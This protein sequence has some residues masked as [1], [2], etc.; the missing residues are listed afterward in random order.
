MEAFSI[1]M[2]DA[3]ATTASNLIE[4]NESFQPQQ[5]ETLKQCG[6]NLDVTE[7]RKSRR[8]S[9][10]RRIIVEEVEDHCDL[11]GE[12][13]S[14]SSAYHLHVKRCQ[15]LSTA[16]FKE[17]QTKSS[18]DL[19]LSSANAKKCGGKVTC[20]HCYEKFWQ[21]EM[22]DHIQDVHG[23]SDMYTCCHCQATFD[24]RRSYASHMRYEH[25]DKKAFKCSFCSN[26]Y[27]LYESLKRHNRIHNKELALTCDECG[28]SF[29]EKITLKRHK[30][31]HTGNI[32]ILK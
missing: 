13:F 10:P 18:E 32:N 3:A 24:S 5:E 21:S 25:D 11:C 26:A 8:K 31:I 16:S 27:E 23:I 28:K 15:D 22:K 12:D 19:D 14:N 20:D 17:T 1:Q 2:E 7:T 9:Q 6:S 29:A 30:T 4:P